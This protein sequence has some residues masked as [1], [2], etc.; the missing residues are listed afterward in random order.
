[1]DSPK[2]TYEV[3]VAMGVETRTTFLEKTPRDRIDDLLAEVCP[4]L[5]MAD[6]DSRKWRDLAQ[7]CYQIG[8]SSIT[9]DVKELDRIEQL[10][11][12]VSSHPD[13]YGA[14]LDPPSP[15]KR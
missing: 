4:E 11:T 12:E 13:S 5:R 10:R 1:M 15:T 6:L 9:H 7:R 3:W 8:R 14:Y 2:I